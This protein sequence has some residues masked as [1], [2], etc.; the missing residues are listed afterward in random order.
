MSIS[1]DSSDTFSF[2]YWEGPKSSDPKVFLGHVTLS[3]LYRLYLSYT[4]P[5]SSFQL[6]L[7]F[8]LLDTG[9]SS[10]RRTLERIIIERK[11]QNLET[12]GEILWI[13]SFEKE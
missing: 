9:L 6:L 3:V 5:V 8:L 2:A 11:Q 13:F 7:N 10:T 4:P 12:L 1:S